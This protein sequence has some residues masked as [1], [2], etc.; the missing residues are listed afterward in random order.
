MKHVRRR[1]VLH[2][3]FQWLG[4]SMFLLVMSLTVLMLAIQYIANED[5]RRTF[6]NGLLDNL[7][8]E[9][10]EKEGSLFLPKVWEERIDQ[11]DGWLQMVDS[12][13]HVVYSYGTPEGLK[14]AY[15]PGELY[16]MEETQKL[17]EYRIFTA[18]DT[19]E[20]ES[21]YFIFGLDDEGGR[22]L[23]RWMASLQGEEGLLGEEAL[24]RLGQELGASGETLHIMGED[25]TVIQSVGGSPGAA[26]YT[27]LELLGMRMEPGSYPAEISLRT[28]PESGNVWILQRTREAGTYESKPFLYDVILGLAVLGAGVFLCTLAFSI[29]HGYRYGRPLLLFI[30]WLERMGQGV[31]HEALTE[32]DRRHVFHRSGKVRRSFRLYREVIEGFEETAARLSAIEQERDRLEK[33]REDCTCSAGKHRGAQQRRRR[34]SDSAAFSKRVWGFGEQ[35]ESAA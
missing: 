16:R 2:F 8:L 20:S 19:F 17:G 1:L 6:P 25:G 12:A 14:T 30:G 3:G 29:W 9:V 15:T 26:A 22:R 28:D 31:Y 4:V 10:E 23:Q 32:K 11:A 7:V 34:D 35:N 21:L 5:L 24:N 33:T 18:L 13:G 27:P